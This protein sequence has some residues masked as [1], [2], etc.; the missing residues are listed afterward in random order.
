MTFNSRLAELI[1]L[2][3]DRWQERVTIHRIA[4]TTKIDDRSL[5]RLF[6]ATPERLYI[7]VLRG[8]CW[9]FR[10]Q[11][12]A[13]LVLPQA[14]TPVSFERTTPP[15]GDVSGEIVSTIGQHIAPF[16]TKFLVEHLHCSHSAVALLRHHRFAAIDPA[17][18][19]ALCNVLEAETIDRLLRYHP[20]LHV[21][22]GD[23]AIDQ[24]TI[25]QADSTTST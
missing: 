7:G 5:R 3:S 2:A 6:N 14:A 18:L 12:S 19:A 13:L 15:S 4:R 23:T 25:I 24:M 21:H 11:P 17:T 20:D 1:T 9:Y 8:L 16:R 10:C 22:A